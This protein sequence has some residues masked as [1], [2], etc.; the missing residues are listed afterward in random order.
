MAWSATR[1]RDDRDLDGRGLTM[2]GEGPADLVQPEPMR[3]QRPRANGAA[4]D[5]AHGFRKL[6]LVDHRAGDGDLPPHHGEEL[7]RRGLMGESGEDDAPSRSHER[8]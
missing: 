3:D 4:A 6:V 8:E 7:D 5:E 1:R 2:H